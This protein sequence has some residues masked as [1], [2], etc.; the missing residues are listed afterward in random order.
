[1][2][3]S[4]SDILNLVYPLWLARL[5]ARQWSPVTEILKKSTTLFS[6]QLDV[7]TAIMLAAK[8]NSFAGDSKN[9][10]N[11]YNIGTGKPIK[12]KDL[13]KVMIKIFRLD[14]EPIF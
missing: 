13:A 6:F 2:P 8:T 11:V 9:N 12:I 14:V 3:I 4:E 1:L 5:L 10:Y 7:I